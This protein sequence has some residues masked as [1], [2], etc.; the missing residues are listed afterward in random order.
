MQNGHTRWASVFL[1]AA[2]AGCLT[3]VVVRAREKGEGRADPVPVTARWEAFHYAQVGSLQTRKYN[4]RMKVRRPGSGAFCTRV[5]L[6]QQDTANTYFLECSESG[7][8][9]GKVEQ[10]LEWPMGWAG[11]PLSPGVESPLL[12]MRRELELKAYVGG[13][14]VASAWDER[15]SGGGVAT[16]GMDETGAVESLRL[17]PVDDVLFSDDFMSA[18]TESSEWQAVSGR[19]RVETLKNPALSS[20]A[21]TYVGESDGDGPAMAVAGYWFWDDIR[22]A[23]SCRPAGPGAI[24]LLARRQATGNA[25]LFRWWDAASR[26]AG[27]REWVR[28]TDGKEE[29]LASADGGYLPGQWYRLEIEALGSGRVAS[30]DGNVA[31]RASDDRFPCGQVGLFGQGPAPVHFDDAYATSKRFFRDTF[32]APSDGRWLFLGGSWDASGLGRMRVKAD[33]RAKALC[34]SMYWNNYRVSA[35]LEDWNCAS[36]GLCA[37]YQDEG[38]G[39]VLRWLSGPG[40]LQLAAL[41]DGVESILEERSWTVPG[42]GPTQLGLGVG[43]GLARGSAGGQVLLEAAVRPDRLS[44][45]AG[46]IVDSGSASFKEVLV[47]FPEASE[48]LQ[49]VN[50]VFA[51]ENSMTEWSARE[52]DW[53]PRRHDGGQAGPPVTVYWH[54]TDFPGDAEMELALPES[55]G[56][57]ASTALILDAEDDHAE[58]GYVLKYQ[59]GPHPFLALDR[60]GVRL[61]EKRLDSE[62]RSLKLS[63]RGRFLLATADW[64]RVWA[65]R[66]AQ[67]LAGWRVAVSTTDGKF[68]TARVEVSSPAV[69]S[70]NFQQAPSEWRQAGGVWSVTSRWQCD[71]RWSFFTGDS[72]GVAA[73]WNKRRF[74]D[75]LTLEFTASIK[76]NS[77]RGVNYEYASD[78]NATLCGDMKALTSGYNFLFGGKRNSGTQLLR[79]SRIV[80]ESP[81]RIPLQVLHRRWFH[82]KIRKRDGLLILWIDGEKVLEYADP[83]PLEGPGVA[84]WTYRNGIQVTR[85]RLSSES[86]QEMEQ[87]AADLPAISRCYYDESSTP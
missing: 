36:V 53:I 19:W 46:L 43:E 76:M 13:E 14:L 12:V 62:L 21:F 31:V 20:N 5:L 25:T 48:P 58:A 75:D 68:D 37:G 39:V 35:V 41:E 49:T 74:Q 86:G 17:Q 50:E 63:R 42:R 3:A 2:L 52:S 61:A 8:R 55:G 64:Q 69:T 6:D 56:Q 32:Q 28:L 85:V 70:Y 84:L 65:H 29:V 78:I 67:P 83:Q 23:V 87:P 18:A 51:G 33:G 10:G 1:A 30:I 57:P 82:L 73:I 16:G 24:G 47:E 22:F 7:T 27:H 59:S 40:R 72:D 9:F 38:Q 44:G 11:R 79:G 71:P 34:G 60:Q 26:P 54:R 77:A 66:E 81:A 80:A 45:K 15:F 4:L